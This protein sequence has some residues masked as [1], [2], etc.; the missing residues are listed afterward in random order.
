[1][2]DTGYIKLKLL[3]LKDNSK[4]TNDDLPVRMW[5]KAEA[6]VYYNNIFQVFII[7]YRAASAFETFTH[8][9]VLHS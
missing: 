6:F 4:N 7:A 8:S 1:M 5:I 2:N 9:Y 3:K